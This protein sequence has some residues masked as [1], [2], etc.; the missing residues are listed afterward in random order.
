MNKPLLDINNLSIASLPEHK[1]LVGPISFTVRQGEPFTLI[2]ET[3]CGK[4]LIAQALAGT[5]SPD[6][7]AS[8]SIE[9]K[10][11]NLVGLSGKERQ[12]LWGR[13]MFLLPQEPLS[14][15]NPTMA[16]IEQVAEVFRYLG[17]QPPTNAL[18]KAGALIA[19][20]GLSSTG[21]GRQYPFRLSGGMNQRILVAIALATP[22]EFIL[23]DEPTKGLD[24]D[25][26]DRVTGLL[27]NLTE[28]G[29]TLLSI[30]HDLAVAR[31]LGGT[32]AVLYGGF[33]VES[34][35]AEHV[36]ACPDHPYTRSL[37]N[38][39]PE[40]GLHPIPGHVLKAMKTAWSDY[41]AARKRR[42]CS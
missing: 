41:A 38:A 1:M 4:T 28:R 35:P 16:V 5:L 21:A 27:R 36:L 3:G 25:L 40:N 37:L 10:G 32:I 7:A 19:G 26:R 6:L 20:L 30:T 39:A 12:K 34:G 33:I 23:A 8:G 42:G 2:G 9:F 14:A 24:P 22:A 29:K 31:H 11:V 13:R 15:L 18:I 17:G